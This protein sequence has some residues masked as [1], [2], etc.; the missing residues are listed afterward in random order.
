MPYGAISFLQGRAAE[1][2]PPSSSI[3]STCTNTFLLPTPIE[4]GP[5][6]IAYT[7]IATEITEYNCGLCQLDVVNPLGFGPQAMSTTTVTAAGTKTV[8][9]ATCAT[10]RFHTVEKRAEIV[11]TIKHGSSGS[12][13][14]FQRKPLA[15]WG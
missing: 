2:T 1:I 12:V 4:L 15:S 8:T 13:S 9:T 10:G 14:N 6:T 3:K 5:T 11:H 7:L